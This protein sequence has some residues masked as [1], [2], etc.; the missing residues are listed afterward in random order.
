MVWSG[1]GTVSAV[2]CRV[3]FAAPCLHP[4]AEGLQL[5]VEVLGGLGQ[6][7][8]G[9]QAGVPDTAEAQGDL[10]HQVVDRV[11]LHVQ[12]LVRVEVDAL[13]GDGQDAEAGAAESGDGHQVVGPHSVT[14]R[15]KRGSW[16]H[17]EAIRL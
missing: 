2:M 10:L 15:Q 17:T 7:P 4:H 6:N 14:C 1:L 13:L 11:S 3:R 16:T 8:A 9:V 5:A 12:G